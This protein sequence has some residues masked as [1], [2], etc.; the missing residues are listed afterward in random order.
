VLVETRD[1][2]DFGLREIVAFSQRRKV[3]NGEVP[4]GVLNAV[5]RLDQ[6]IAAAREVPRQCNHFSSPLRGGAA[7]PRGGP[8]WDDETGSSH[9]VLDTIGVMRG[10]STTASA[11]ATVGVPCI[12]TIRAIVIDAS[13]LIF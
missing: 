10:P 4:E 7:A 12:R 11:C 2:K 6:Q 8:E 9:A 3:R 13:P 5:E 1:L